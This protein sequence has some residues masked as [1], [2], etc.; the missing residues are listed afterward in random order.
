MHQSD[1]Q[2]LWKQRRTHSSIAAEGDSK[3]DDNTG[4]QKNPHLIDTGSSRVLS[5]SYSCK[6]F[7][8]FTITNQAQLPDFLYFIHIL[9]TISSMPQYFL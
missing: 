6:I 5:Y 2:L 3:E 9:S 8:I 4:V 1:G 7:S